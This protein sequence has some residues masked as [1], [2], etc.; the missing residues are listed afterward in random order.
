[1]KQWKIDEPPGGYTGKIIDQEGNT[2]AIVNN[3]HDAIYIDHAVRFLDSFRELFE[4]NS[5]LQEAYINAVEGN[6]DS[7]L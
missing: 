4:K 2:I 5:E 3:F 1:M 6:Y 7:A